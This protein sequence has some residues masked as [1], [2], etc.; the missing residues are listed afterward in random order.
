M[1]KTYGRLSLTASDAV[2]RA[3]SI[4]K[5]VKDGAA[6]YYKL[7][8]GG[9]N[10][11]VN[12]PLNALGQADCSGFVAWACGY[13][14]F[15]G[16]HGSRERWVNTDAILYA[17]YPEAVEDGFEN[18]AALDPDT[19]G[20]GKMVGMFRRIG[21]Q[22]PIKPGDILVYGSTRVGGERRPGHTGIIVD[23][24]DD[25]VRGGDLWWTN[26]GVAHCAPSNSRKL[27]SGHAI[28]VTSAAAWRKKGYIV[29]PVFYAT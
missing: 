26:L 16:Y 22:D 17:A 14:R 29:R 13:D 18:E 28:A 21:K 10:P 7:G 9:R 4:C 19:S 24:H 5:K 25:F 8:T 6:A 3:S 20:N 1:I 27:G 11:G 2:A 15:Q 12:S 23:V